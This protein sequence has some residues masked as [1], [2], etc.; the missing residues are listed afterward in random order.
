[1]VAG[2]LETVSGVDCVFVAIDAERETRDSTQKIVLSDGSRPRVLLAEDSGAA[3]ILTA[4]LLGRMGCDVDAV[5]DGEEALACV[6]LNSYD[7]IVLDIEMPVMDGVVA[8]REIRALGG[9]KAQIPIIAF[10]AFLADMSATGIVRAVFDQTLAKPAGRQ[11]IRSTLEHALKPKS[12]AGAALNLESIAAPAVESPLG[13]VDTQALQSFRA[14]LAQTMWND[15]VAAAIAEMQQSLEDAGLALERLNLDAM[16][17]HCH[18]LKGFARTFA[19]PQM[20]A[21]AEALENRLH[22]RDLDN[23]SA[24]FNRLKGCIGRTVTALG[25]VCRV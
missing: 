9:A 2:L 11:A 10:S 4:A 3:R 25:S 13:L 12:K 21:I 7:V 23:C 1:M 15:F 8:A 6:K 14:H 18:K 19:A 24:E 5:E 16:H 22:G 20:A 17:H